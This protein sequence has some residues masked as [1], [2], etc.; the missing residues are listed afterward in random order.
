[1][2]HITGMW[3][4]W[5]I[6]CAVK[7]NIADHLHKQPLSIEALS[8][9]TQTH[10]VSLYRMM[11]ALAS[12]GIFKEDEEKKWTLTPMA[13][14]LRGDNQKSLK[15]TSLSA[16]DDNH[17]MWSHLLTAIQTGNGIFEKAYGLRVDQYLM[18]NP[19]YFQ[20]L[21]GALQEHAEMY[22]NHITEVYDFSGFKHIV[23]IG[24]HDGSFLALILKTVNAKGTVFDLQYAIDVAKNNSEIIALGNRCELVVGDF[25]KSVPGDGDCYIMKSTLADWFDENAVKILNNI[26]IEMKT[27]SKLLIIEPCLPES[28]IP[29]FGKIQDLLNLVYGGGKYRTKREFQSLLEA[30]GLR[31]NRIIPLKNEM[32]DI[33]EVVK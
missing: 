27:N 28:N 4:S 21:R 9:L 17:L 32:Y 22:C 20:N 30:S 29:H 26:A 31:L 5:V 33:M 12:I 16:I 6:C 1:M 2:E 25:F 24:G 15:F 19:I 13:E 23:D 11:R 7:L 3:K 10:T 18:S 8:D 14:L